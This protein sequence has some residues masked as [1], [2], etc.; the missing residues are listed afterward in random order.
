MMPR[1]VDVTVA[2]YAYFSSISFQ[3]R[4]YYDASVFHACCLPPGL[5]PLEHQA[6][7]H[8][9]LHFHFADTHRY[10]SLFCF[11][12]DRHDRRLNFCFIA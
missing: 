11:T 6:T 10:A 2:Y 5:L 9:V 4:R 12:P 7:R 3:S 1:L 8:A